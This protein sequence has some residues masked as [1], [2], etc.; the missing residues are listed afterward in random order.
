ME[1]ICYLS[2]GYPNLEAS[3]QLAEYYVKGGCN[4][5]EIDLPSRDPYLEGEYI[6]NRMAEALKACDDYDKYME[7]ILEMKRRLPNT[8]F[9]LLSYENTV[10]EIGVEKFSSFCLEN[11]LKDIILVGLEN[12]EIKNKLIEKGLKVSCYVQFQMD[13]NEIKSAKASNGFVYMQA[14]PAPEQINPKFPTLADCIQKLR[15]E[16]IQREIYCGVG[17]Y[18]PEDFKMVKDSKGDGAFVG[19]TILK[20][21]DNPPKLMETIA[22]LKAV[23]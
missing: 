12:E 5:I 17:V 14:K 16:G 8:G 21:Y 23:D 4:I 15:D 11:D 3:V 9:F 19:S 6:A 7:N 18:T 22:A 13:E 2:N 20:L 10:K 1:L